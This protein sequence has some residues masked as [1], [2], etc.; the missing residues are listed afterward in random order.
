MYDK[1]QLEP[2]R[3]SVVL[4]CKPVPLHITRAK[5]CLLSVIERPCDKACSVSK[6]RKFRGGGCAETRFSIVDIMFS[7]RDMF[8]RSSKSVPKTAVF[9]PSPWGVKRPGC[10]EQI[11]QILV[12]NE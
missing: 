11:F 4:D 1:A 7:C 2:A 5:V 10:S 9:A 3:H 6:V 12:I 8:D